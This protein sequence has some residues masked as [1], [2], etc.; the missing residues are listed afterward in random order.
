MNQSCE[1]RFNSWGGGLVCWSIHE[2]DTRGADFSSFLFRCDCTPR[3]CSTP[4][5]SLGRYCCRY[6]RRGRRCRWCGNRSIFSARSREV[7]CSFP[8]GT[9]VVRD[10]GEDTA[11]LC[12]GQSA[13]IQ[14]KL[15][16]TGQTKLVVKALPGNEAGKGFFIDT[17]LLNGKQGWQ[18]ILR[19]RARR[20]S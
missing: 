15:L 9:H 6:R 7:I 12:R 19:A 20:R 3:N 14:I 1:V 18:R 13:I 5:R 17:L 11:L 4:S 16:A 8:I 2:R 10:R